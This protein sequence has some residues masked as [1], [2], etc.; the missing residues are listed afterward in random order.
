MR[1]FCVTIEVM[2]Q[3]KKRNKKYRGVDAVRNDVVRVHRVKAVTRSRVGQFI[4]DNATKL[5]YGA[6]IVI[7]IALVILG[8]MSIR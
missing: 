5:K 1:W 4:H 7:A 2:K 3:A 6:I 8:I